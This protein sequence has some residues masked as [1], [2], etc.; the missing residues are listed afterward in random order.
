MKPKPLR[1]PEIETKV[2]PDGHIVLVC[3]KTSWANTLTPLAA[4]IWE[5]CDGSNSVQEIVTNVRACVEF[6]PGRNLAQEV[7]ALIQALE[8]KGVLLDE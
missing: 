5:Y 3:S 1:N 4:L 7:S 8:D 2:L 6:E